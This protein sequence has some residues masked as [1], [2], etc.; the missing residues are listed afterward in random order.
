MVSLHF[1]QPITGVIKYTVGGTAAGNEDYDALPGSIN[2]SGNS[3]DI[4]IAIRNDSHYEG[5]E[6]IIL[7][8]LFGNDYLLGVKRS[9]TVTLKD[10]PNESSADYLFNLSTLT[11]GVYGTTTGR[12]GFPGT[13]FSRMAST[14]ITFSANNVLKAHIN[15]K[16]SLG[17]KDMN[18]TL[19]KIHAKSLSYSTGKLVMV[20]E[21][22][23]EYDGFVKG[24]S[25]I[26][27]DSDKPELDN[28]SEKIRLTNTLTLT[29]KNVVTNDTPPVTLP[30][31]IARDK[32]TYN[33]LEGSFS[34]SI[35][36]VL[37][38]STGQFYEGILR[39]TMQ[40]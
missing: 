18:D 1:N 28:Q 15:E 11:P 21:Y 12:T 40:P 7:S 39:G 4:Q 32:F 27:F 38:E 23:T 31:D 14:N 33:Y 9:H 22:L 30:F 37:N 10:N 35:S 2:V 29:I 17:F 6:T 25:L 3:A 19:G 26:S 13:I 34:L 20:F 5:D 24:Q 16:R 8:L 36:G